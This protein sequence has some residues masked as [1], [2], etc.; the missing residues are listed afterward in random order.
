MSKDATRIMLLC[1]AASVA[2]ANAQQAGPT[3]EWPLQRQHLLA[4]RYVGKLQAYTQDCQT[5]RAELKLD[6]RGANEALHPYTLTTTCIDSDM[7]HTA[8]RTIA[9]SWSL[10]QLGGSC[11]MLGFE[12]PDDPL[13]GP[14]LYGFR[15]EEANTRPRRGEGANYVLAQDGSNCHSGMPP[16]HQD[17]R[18]RRVR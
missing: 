4:G 14:N 11:L 10:D 12:D 17:K 7:R 1:L 2:T 5:V 3:D 8:P 13:V 9:G 18:L 15:L 6:V 16:E